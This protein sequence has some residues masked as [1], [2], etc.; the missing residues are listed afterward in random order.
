MR[1][2]R[3]F[4]S[5]ILEGVTASAASGSVERW[6]DVLKQ[7]GWG[8][9]I[10]LVIKGSNFQGGETVSLTISWTGADTPSSASALFE[11]SRSRR[12]EL[13]WSNRPIELCGNL[14]DDV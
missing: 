9:A 8:R 2:L 7:E 12:N 11:E 3:K 10:G 5:R 1:A 6:D 4:T 14:G 13:S